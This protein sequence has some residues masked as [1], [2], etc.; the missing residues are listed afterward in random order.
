MSGTL[1]ADHPGTEEEVVSEAAPTAL[2][3]TY[4]ISETQT[5]PVGTLQ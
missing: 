4:P 2:T 3:G 1:T 5:Q